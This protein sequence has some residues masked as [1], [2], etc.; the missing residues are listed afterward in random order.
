MTVD[1]YVLFGSLVTAACCYLLPCAWLACIALLFIDFW[2]VCTLW[3]FCNGSLL[4]FTALCMCLV[5]PK[6]GLYNCNCG[7]ECP[8]WRHYI[9][10]RFIALFNVFILRAIS[11][12]EGE[13]FFI[14]YYYSFIYWCFTGFYPMVWYWGLSQRP[15][16]YNIT[17]LKLISYRYLW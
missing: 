14:Y 10:E 9:L 15:I 8:L 2:F 5:G 4:I 17:C 11:W 12:L 3:F 6:E 7:W 13:L 1:L 16:I